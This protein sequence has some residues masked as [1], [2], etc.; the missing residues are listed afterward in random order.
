MTEMLL[1]FS[2]FII[3]HEHGTLVSLLLKVRNLY[4]SLQWF[5]ISMS[6]PNGIIHNFP[7][8]NTQRVRGGVG[9]PTHHNK[10]MCAHRLSMMESF[11]LL[12]FFIILQLSSLLL[13]S[14]D[15]LWMRDA[16]EALP[17]T[18]EMKGK[19]TLMWKI[20]RKKKQQQLQT[21]MCVCALDDLLNLRIWVHCIVCRLS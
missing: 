12:T 2:R 7:V 5:F 3:C 13:Y 6:T 16:F 10:Q 1:D 4:K 20:R 17:P 8:C 18:D 21:A 19:N 14:N 9:R 11:P 15:A